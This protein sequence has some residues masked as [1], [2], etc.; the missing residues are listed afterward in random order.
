MASG[1]RYHARARVLLM[2]VKGAI[3]S[4]RERRVR[5]RRGCRVR[6]RTACVGA[7]FAYYCAGAR[8]C[9]AVAPNAAS[10]SLRNLTASSF[11][12]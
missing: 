3:G 2:A 1:Q 11:A 8:S 5:T 7:R 12:S 4:A 6:D 10:I 9:D